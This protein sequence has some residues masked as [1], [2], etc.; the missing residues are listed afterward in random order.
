MTVTLEQIEK[1]L[2]IPK[3]ELIRK[4][5]HRYLEFELRYLKTEI[6]KIHIKYGVHSFNNLWNKIE[7]GKI[8]ESKCF[9][10]L[11]KLE[12][13]EARAEKVES[14]LREYPSP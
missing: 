14:L 8:T 10:D 12:Y 1:E 9:D 4:G 6:S 3:D 7:E 5:V 11:T 13:L 2:N